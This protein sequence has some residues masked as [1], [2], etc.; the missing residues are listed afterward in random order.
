MISVK[1]PDGSTAQF[2]DGTPPETIKAAIQKKFSATSPGP[3]ALAPVDPNAAQS[4]GAFGNNPMAVDMPD[5]TPEVPASF[6]DYVRS[7]G[8][9]IDQVPMAG[10]S[11][12]NAMREARAKAQG[13]TLEQVDAET[14]AARARAPGA[15]V[16][17]KLAYNIAPYAIAGMFGPTARM[18]GITGKTGIEGAPIL[19]KVGD[20]AAR[21]GA[22]FFS[23][24]AIGT[25][26]SMARGDDFGTAAQQNLAP[27]LAVGS[28]PVAG[29]TLRTAARYA[30]KATNWVLGGAPS[31]FWQ[32]LNKERA[33]Q[34]MVGKTGAFDRS[35]GQTLSSAEDAAALANGQTLINLDRGGPA[36]RNLA[37]V[38]A[39]KSPEGKAN[40]VAAT[41]NTAPGLDTAGFL[42]TLVGGSADDV[43]LREGLQK[44]ARQVNAPAYAKA[45]AHPNAQSI[46]TPEIQ[47][48]MHAP[49]F[50]RA[51]REAEGSGKTWAALH[52]GKPVQS[53]FVFAPDGTV[54]MKPGVTPNLKFWDQVQR[55]LRKQAEALGP[56]EKAAF[57]EVDGLRKQLLSVL[58]TAVP[59]FKKARLGAAGFF[60]AEDAMDAGRKFASQ[61]RNLPEATKAFN[62]MS[63]VDQKAFRIGAA[64]TAIDKLKTGDSFAVVKQTFG[65]PAA[66]EFWKVVLGPVKAGQLEAYVKVQAIKNG[67]R[68][69][70]VGGSQTF[71]L[72]SGA[73]LGGAGVVADNVAPGNPFTNVAYFLAAGRV[74]HHILGRTVDKEIMTKVANLL[75][76]EDKAA[77]NKIVANASM[78]PRWMAALNAITTG[79]ASLARGGTIA[80][81]APTAAM[82]TPQTDTR[83]YSNGLPPALSAG[84]RAS[85]PMP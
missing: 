63:E 60:G 21:T 56:K 79:A 53:P 70:V 29:A 48:L 31:T 62:A 16:A 4:P 54:T 67:S 68:Q 64:S 75:A 9:N 8:A 45:E 26:D 2:P 46:F 33:A 1:L 43:A 18:L 85:L 59:D 57:S 65:S 49:E 30:P 13:M 80:A 81:M 7:F 82:A 23:N 24:E 44:T 72:I 22:A 34:R 40:L 76:S 3:R 27:S 74:A 47:Q 58:D 25:A 42:T 12:Y 73:G 10:P 5:G 35:A 17:G 66:R 38:A 77:L 78:S 6:D 55:N 15:D 52:G 41:D 51:V 39:A 69:A 71:D 32:M 84:P 14:A 83:D 28:L 11:I 50:L 36:T 37:R 19:T 61:P 20:L